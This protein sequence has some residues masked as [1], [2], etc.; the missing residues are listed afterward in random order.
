M[1]YS[2]KYHGRAVKGIRHASSEMRM[3]IMSRLDELCED[4]YRGTRMVGG[5]FY[6]SRVSSRG[7]AYR[8]IYAIDNDE[9]S[10]S[11]HNIGKHKIL[12]C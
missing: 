5:E 2:A 9:R 8:I 12:G 10:I 7:G 11:F 6:E 3:R 1:T 4:P